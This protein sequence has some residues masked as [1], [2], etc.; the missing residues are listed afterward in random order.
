MPPQTSESILPRDN[1]ETSKPDQVGPIDETYLFVWSDLA[2]PGSS[3]YQADTGNRI[4]IRSL[5]SEA[6]SNGAFR[7]SALF[8]WRTLGAVLT[9]LYYP[10]DTPSQPFSE[11]HIDNFELQRDTRTGDMSEVEAVCINTVRLPTEELE[12]GPAQDD[13]G[14]DFMSIDFK[15]GQ[16]GGGPAHVYLIGKRMVDEREGIEGIQLTEAER[17]RV[18][19]FEAEWENAKKNE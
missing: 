19:P 13:K 9:C 5:S 2:G 3:R 4:R 15:L 10:P 14:N 18:G 16:Q 7:C 6:E 1:M 12:I 11:A 17:L 8:S